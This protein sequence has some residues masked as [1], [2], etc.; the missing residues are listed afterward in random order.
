MSQ[1]MRLV[2]S[3]AEPIPDN[4]VWIECADAAAMLGLSDRQIRREC[5]QVWMA[6]GLS[7]MDK[8]S[9]GILT[10][11]VRSDADPALRPQPKA[12]DRN[13]LSNKQREILDYRLRIVREWKQIQAAGGR[14]ELTSARKQFCLANNISSGTLH[15]WVT[16]SDGGEE[17]LLDGR[18]S[19][20]N[21]VVQYR[22][23]RAEV[24]RQ[25]L[26]EGEPKASS[27]HRIARAM[28]RRNGWEYP[29][30]THI[31]KDVVRRLK[32]RK[33][34][35]VIRQRE[36]EDAFLNRVCA[37]DERDYE[38]IYINGQL[39]EMYSNDIWCGDHHPCDV[40]CWKPRHG[41]DPNGPRNERTGHFFRPWLTAWEDI[42]SRRIVGRYFSDVPPT[43]T[44]VLLALRDAIHHCGNCVPN[45]VY[46]DNG[47]DYDVWWMQ[48]QTKWQRRQYKVW[49][50]GEEEA[51]K[52]QVLGIYQRLTIEV[53]HATPYNAKAKPVERWFGFYE[54]DFGKL[55]P[56]Y[57]GR[58]P[59]EKPERLEREL[60][61]GSAPTLEEYSARASE[62]IDSIYHANH[63]HSGH[64][65]YLRTPDAVYAASLVEK[66]MVP[67][68]DLNDC[69]AIPG[70]LVTVGSNGIRL[71]GRLYG[72]GDPTLGSF[73]GQK[74][75][76][77]YDP[78]DITWCSIW[79]ADGIHLCDVEWNKRAIFGAMKEDQYNEANR[80]SRR[81]NKSL[82]EVSKR[83]LHL[84]TDPTEIILQDAREQIQEQG[85]TPPDRPADV[86]KII[87]SGLERPSQGEAIPLRKA[88][89]AESMTSMKP[90]PTA[91]PAI[92]WSAYA[93][94]DSDP[95]PASIDL[96][97]DEEAE[98]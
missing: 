6:K 83:G 72:Q 11:F 13:A 56:T 55:Q 87:R 48:G 21:S 32:T 82:R 35:A 62:W 22:E 73:F 97:S 69:L 64:G 93:E 77:R 43:S 95:Q 17:A 96:F 94:D 75:E 46:I 19:P 68:A 92:D 33:L 42:R 34:S 58:N 65:M 15:N 26:H 20:R 4:V 81:H 10:Y 45:W 71:K 9:A 12:F 41:R 89:G 98:P 80:T 79:S 52:N 57:T 84:I 36:G 5:V 90:T 59:Q 24:E 23:Y 70:K 60:K 40:L 67:E 2:G 88:V 37:Y 49:S 51:E 38:H 74:V 18:S 47:K 1:A 31:A 25:Y 76:P 91:R 7:R 78:A 54:S 28:A 30:G 86:V 16:G 14:G 29:E 85:L 39:R 3:P 44:N 50:H 27:C 8:G 53:V 63:Q 66:R 61:A